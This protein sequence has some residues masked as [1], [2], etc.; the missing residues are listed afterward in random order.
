MSRNAMN[1]ARTHCRKSF[2]LVAGT[3]LVACLQ[4]QAQAGAMLPC[5]APEVFPGAAVQVFLL[6]YQSVGK[7]TTRGQQL[8]TIL[9]RHVLYAAL[10]YPSIAVE[11]LTVGSESHGSECDYDATSHRVI[12]QL[13][14]GQVVVFLWGRLFEQDQQLELQS[15]VSYTI[16]GHSDTLSWGSPGRM[17]HATMPDSSIL[18]APRTIPLDFLSGL[19][20]AQLEASRL[21]VNPE[22]SSPST[23]LPEGADARF[24]YAVLGTQGD[25][26][27]I[28]LYPQGIEGW[29]PAHALE[30]AASLKGI[31]PELYFLDGLVG[32][33]ELG[34]GTPPA[35]E[36]RKGVLAG[37]ARSLDQYGELSSSRAE[38][39]TRALAR[40][41]K[42]S[43]QWRAGL[44]PDGDTLNSIYQQYRNAAQQFPTSLVARN[45]ALASELAL[46]LQ[47]SCPD[48]IEDLQSQFLTAIGS[49]PTNPELLSNLSTFYANV[50]AGSLKLPISKEDLAKQQ[51]LVK[52]AQS[53][54]A[55]SGALHQ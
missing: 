30:T 52:Q 36:A 42:A 18:F 51:S 23:P 4:S 12:P 19:Q 17:T 3:L 55:R 53:A 32:Y 54:Q 22:A 25:W 5:A 44:S 1:A 40:V 9:Q 11:Q 38:S 8:A 35:S 6:P 37:T 24:G 49:D 14:A 50:G 47:Q 28:H 41:M 29:I 10:K 34:A 45:F 48:P 20:M 39:A 46:C 26:M 43:A 33:G 7:L 16:V 31:F 27:H 2:R 13:K 21:H 15:T